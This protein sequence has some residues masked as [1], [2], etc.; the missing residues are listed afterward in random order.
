MS[1]L[2]NKIF[3]IGRNYSKK[4]EHKITDREEFKIVR[5]TLVRYGMSTDFFDI[6][7][8]DLYIPATM[9]EKGAVTGN[10]NARNN[11]MEFTTDKYIMIHELFHMASRNPETTN[12]LM[13]VLLKDNKGNNTGMGF[14]EGITDYFTHLACPEYEVAYPFEEKVIS[15]LSETFGIKVFTNHFNASP[16]EFYASFG[17]D[18]LF[19]M[20]ISKRLDLYNKSLHQYID[21]FQANDLA[22]L[23]KYGNKLAN[24]ILDGLYGV[25]N[26]LYDLL[27]LKGIDSSK[28]K[29]EIKE[30]LESD[31]NNMAQIR[32]I[33][34]MSNQEEMKL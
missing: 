12:D 6:N 7:L 17:K 26:K 13:G 10:Y 29:N 2:F 20:E 27:E 1:E 31:N 19:I 21:L 32:A 16:N 3:D 33:I 14:N 4:V 11:S 30:L 28:Y 23:I 24:N 8:P 9:H 15:I 22:G 25:C 5:D 18:Q 34:G